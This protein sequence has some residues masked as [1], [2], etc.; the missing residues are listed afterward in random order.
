MSPPDSEMFQGIR[1]AAE[2]ALDGVRLGDPEVRGKM[3][4]VNWGDLRVV[5]VLFCIDEHGRRTWRVLIE[6]ASPTS[7]LAAPICTRL[8]KLWPD[9]VFEV[10]T[11]W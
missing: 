11:E 1:Q 10:A 8:A 3:G 9:E 5:E 2:Q 6:E 4:A 7:G